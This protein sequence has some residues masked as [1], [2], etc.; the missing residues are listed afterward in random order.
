[1]YI[2][3]ISLLMSKKRD[4]IQTR[5]IVYKVVSLPHLTYIRREVVQMTIFEAIYLMIT[6]GLFILALLTYI[7]RNTKRK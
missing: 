6:F 1:M 5:L 4:K 7:D 2:S 3:K